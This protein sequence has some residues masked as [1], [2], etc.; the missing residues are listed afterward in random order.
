M[1]ANPLVYRLRLGT[2]FSG[3]CAARQSAPPGIAADVPSPLGWRR[4][5]DLMRATLELAGEWWARG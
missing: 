2:Q 4:I 5:D 3:A 1:A